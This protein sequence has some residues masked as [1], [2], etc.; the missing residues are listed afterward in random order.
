ME[1]QLGKAGQSC[2]FLP[3]TPQKGWLGAVTATGWNRP[4]GGRGPRA[5][6]PLLPPPSAQPR[7]QSCQPRA[8]STRDP[9]HKAIF[10]TQRKTTRP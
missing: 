5:K 10:Y 4:G 8:L 3:R 7:F 1:P 2:T 6:F 9:K